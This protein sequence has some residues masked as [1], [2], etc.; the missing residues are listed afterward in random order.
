MGYVE[1]LGED[2]EECLTYLCFPEA[3]WKATRTTN[4]LERLIGEGRRRTK[5]IP[6]F[7]S[8]N[9]C[10]RLLYI[11]LITASQSWKD[12]KITPDIWW[13]LEALGRGV[14]GEHILRDER[15]LMAA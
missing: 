6:R 4:I 5:V 8:E 14:F 7:P 1:C 15:E 3:H 9:A 2:L 11:S 13:E 12:M 10:L